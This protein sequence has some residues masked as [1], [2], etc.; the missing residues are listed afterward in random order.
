MNGRSVGF[1]EEAFVVVDFLDSLRVGREGSRLVIT[2]LVQ[3]GDGTE[4]ELRTPRQRFSPL[5]GVLNPLSRGTPARGGRG[6]KIG[7]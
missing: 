7:R 2:V 4:K 1:L 5:A 3:R 6:G